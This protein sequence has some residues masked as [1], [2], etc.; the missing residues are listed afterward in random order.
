M[1]S[2][3]ENNSRNCNWKWKSAHRVANTARWL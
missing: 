1:F 3:K 2:Q